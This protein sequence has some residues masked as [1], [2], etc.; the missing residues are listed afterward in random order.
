MHVAVLPGS[1]PKQNEAQFVGAGTFDDG[2]HI[3][4]IELSWLRLDLLPLDWSLDGIGVQGSHRFPDLREFA[5]PAAGVV[6]LSTEDEVWPAIH[7][8]SITGILFDE[9]GT[10]RGGCITECRK[11]T[12][13]KQSQAINA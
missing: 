6:D 5:G 4:K 13:G 9:P 10:I 11:E 8:Q 2:V 3:V 12:E 1:E 7:H